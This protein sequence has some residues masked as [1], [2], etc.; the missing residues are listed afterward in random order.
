MV[1]EIYRSNHKHKVQN[2]TQTPSK[3]IL[4]EECK[5]QTKIPPQKNLEGEYIQWK[6]THEK[7][8]LENQMKDNKLF[9]NLLFKCAMGISH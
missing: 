8:N 4:L 6:Q 1:L 2:I 5:I 3:S 7:F 9:T